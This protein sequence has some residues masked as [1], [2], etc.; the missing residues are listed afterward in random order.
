[1]IE[2]KQYSRWITVTAAMWVMWLI[3]MLVVMYIG[4][5]SVSDFVILFAGFG[6]GFATRGVKFQ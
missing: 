1:M 6:H 5:A 4:N 2:T 3:S